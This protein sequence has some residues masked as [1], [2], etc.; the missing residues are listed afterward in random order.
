MV[1]LYKFDT[2]SKPL[3]E[4]PILSPCIGIC[5]IDNLGLC[6]GCFRTGEEISRWT[7][8]SQAE[9]QHVMDVVLVQREQIFGS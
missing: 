4:E 5:H 2:N 7:Q 6:E 1:M 9:R 8:M 3:S